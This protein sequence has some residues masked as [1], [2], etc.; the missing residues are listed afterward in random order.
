MLCIEEDKVQLF[1]KLLWVFESTFSQ[2]GRYVVQALGFW[3]GLEV[4]RVNLSIWQ[5]SK[6]VR[7]VP[8]KQVST[9][10]HL[11]TLPLP[12]CHPSYCTLR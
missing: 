12:T 10:L 8:T 9:L 1:E 6:D 2:A 11:M 4:I 5:L 7:H 3:D